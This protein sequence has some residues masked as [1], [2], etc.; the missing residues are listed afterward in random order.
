M[1]RKKASDYFETWRTKTK[2]GFLYHAHIL[3]SNDRIGSYEKWGSR[4]GRSRRYQK[5]KERY[6]NLIRRPKIK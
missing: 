5:L 1:S 6:S 4:A 2:K 3:Y